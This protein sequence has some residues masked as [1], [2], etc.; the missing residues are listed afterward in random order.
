MQSEKSD[1]DTQTSPRTKINTK[2][3]TE[4]GYDGKEN[5]SGSEYSLD[6]WTLSPLSFSFELGQLS[7]LTCENRAVSP[8]LTDPTGPEP[9][10]NQESHWVFHSDTEGEAGHFHSLGKY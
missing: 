4:S 7:R 1:T 9:I 10:T 2:T 6:P 8:C 3:N 5:P